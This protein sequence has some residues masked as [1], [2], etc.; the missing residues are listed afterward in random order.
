MKTHK[1]KERFDQLLHVMVTQPVYLRKSLQKK[2]RFGASFLDHCSGAA[3]DN[4]AAAASHSIFNRTSAAMT[5]SGKSSR[6]KVPET[7]VITPIRSM[8]LSVISIIAARRG[9]ASG[10]SFSSASICSA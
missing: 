8:S 1:A 6:C 9:S 2:F 5:S 3:L 10:F 4:D 7:I